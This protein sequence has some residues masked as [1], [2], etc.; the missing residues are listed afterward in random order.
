VDRWNEAGVSNLT[1]AAESKVI[2]F[3]HTRDRA[4]AKAFYGGVL[5]FTLVSDDPF[6]AVFDLNGIKLRITQIDNHVANPHT[7]LGW[8]VTDIVGAIKALREHGVAMNIY[9]GMGQDE[10]GIWTSPD[11]KA[12]V[13]F[14]NDPDG[15][16]LSLTSA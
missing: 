13:A 2:T 7:V 6:A 16:G 10:L 4:K 5:G 14:F 11:G 15:N 12:K 9:K 8:E 3:I 1:L